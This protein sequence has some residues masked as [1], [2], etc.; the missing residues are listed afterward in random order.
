MKTP[1]ILLSAALGFTFLTAACVK[2]NFDNP[3]DNS[4]YD[5][6]LTV[7]NSLR[8]LRLMNG[9][10]DYKTGGATTT[11][12]G[13]IIVAGIVTADDRSGNLYK[14]INVEDSTGGMQVM[15]D[16]YSLYNSYPVG[17]KIYIRCRGLTLGYNGGTPVLGMGVSEQ[18][19][20]NAI[21]GSEI[22]N[23]IVKADMGHVV[24]PK[25]VTLAQLAQT[26]NYDTSLINRLVMITEAQFA[27]ISS[28][29][30]YTQPNG[31]TNR[32]LTDCSG[33]I[34]ALRSSNYATFHAIPLPS[35]KGTITGLYS[36]YASAFSGAISPQ[37]SIRDTSDVQMTGYRCG[38]GAMPTAG[39]LITID[40]L[41]KMYPGTGK[42]TIGSVKV[43]GVV[44][45]DLAN[46]NVSA[47]NFILE[48]KSQKGIIL[49]L[50]GG[51]F[52]LG[53]SLVIDASGAKL[54]LYNG[55]MEL[56]G[57][58]ASKITK[59]ATGKAVAPIQKTI[60]E[61]NAN[62]NLYESV[63]IK[64]VNATISGGG[65]YSGNKTINDGTGTM[66]LYTAAAASFAGT[67]VPRSPKTFVGIG[68]L[69]TP[70]EIKLRDPFID[71]Y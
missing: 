19:A 53:D 41:R 45:S 59:A 10:F 6:G 2:K 36:V 38:G 47:G 65:S 33:K 68:T 28:G 57:V 34:I 14:S 39:A 30:T 15:I 43:T 24:T 37:L 51:N 31:S 26:K 56:T 64:V 58:N 8:E 40:S 4:N 3:P 70:N 32:D 63:L 66:S 12:S 11:I 7:T 13:D 29:I 27:D 22:T 18:N 20:I 42:Y 16:A 23:H 62:F 46:G 60:A 17:R 48:D 69:Y 71:V 25:P 44:I 35:G 1:V 54:E 61:L 5:P 52:S 50:S 9:R 55:A 49:F 21:P 67:N